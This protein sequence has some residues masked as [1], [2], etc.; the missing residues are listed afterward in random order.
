MPCG[1]HHVIKKSDQHHFDQLMEAKNFGSQSCFCPPVHA[2]KL[3]FITALEHPR[4]VYSS[5]C[6]GLTGLDKVLTIYDP[7]L[8]LLICETAQNK[9]WAELTLSQTIRKNLTNSLL[10]NAQL[11]LYQF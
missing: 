1:T 3:C 8:L 2:L 4:L 11:I 9:L 6:T 7:G 10:V 5:D